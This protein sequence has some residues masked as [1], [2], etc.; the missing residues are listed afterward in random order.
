[1]HD[2]IAAVSPTESE[3][4]QAMERHRGELHRLC[5]RLLGSQDAE[6]ALQET[7]LRA[8][9]SRGK[10]TNSSPRGW[11]YAI[12]TNTCYDAIAR[13]DGTCPLDDSH[14]PQAPPDQEPDAR[15]V[16]R[17]TVELALL[18]AIQHLPPLQQASFV[19]RDVLSWSAQDTPT[20]RA[21]SLPATNS[22][23]Q[24]ARRQLRT[25]L[26]PGRLHWKC[27]EPCAAQRRTLHRYLCALDAPTADVAT[28]L[29]GSGLAY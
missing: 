3:F 2:T 29:M 4:T 21:T 26:A 10:C 24:R 15:T 12:A 1:M 25:R 22:A 8:W 9:R 23:L 6:D 13:R 27:E 19:L 28:H 11:L 14:E 18:T 5:V 7:L 17:E 20:A 16:D